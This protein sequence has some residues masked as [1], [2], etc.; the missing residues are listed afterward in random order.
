M[1]EAPPQWVLDTFG[2]DGPRIREVVLETVAQVHE[3][4]ASAQQVSGMSAQ[5]VYGQIWRGLIDAFA[6]E[7]GGELTAELVRP[8]KAP[9][10]VPSI[11]NVLLFPWRYGDG[12]LT[13]SQDSL[14]DLSHSRR[15]MFS[16]PLP[17]NV[18]LPFGAGD[19]VRL[20]S[21]SELVDEIPAAEWAETFSVVVVAIASSSQRLHTVEWGLA[22]LDGYGCI[23]WSE[24]EELFT[25]ATGL[26]SIEESSTADFASG[27][28]PRA[29]V[30][31]RK[32]ADGDV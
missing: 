12:V 24:H 23:E 17:G 13:R 29:I 20:H 10:R 14:F 8:G 7:L 30:K 32:T 27:E 16:M 1:E 19:S 3:R 26:T 31:P 9:Y 11:G 2:D 15:Q 18:M 21:A 22:S 28:P 6:L 5:G 25:A 4:L